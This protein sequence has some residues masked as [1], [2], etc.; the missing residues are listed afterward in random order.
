MMP[1][2]TLNNPTWRMALHTAQ[3]G[4]VKALHF[5]FLIRKT[6]QSF[7]IS[8]I[9]GVLGLF[10]KPSKYK[11]HDQFS[12]VILLKDKRYCYIEAQKHILTNEWT[13]GTATFSRKLN[14]LIGD[15][16]ADCVEKLK[17]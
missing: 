3:Q 5:G 16:D 12:A 6:T 10:E 2:A 13:Y 9:E 14:A 8:D 11:H 7:I 4:Y 15:L 1:S 17:L